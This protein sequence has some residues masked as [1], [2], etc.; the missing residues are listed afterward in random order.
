M[1]GF[2]EMKSHWVTSSLKQ[3]NRRVFIRDAAFFLFLYQSEASAHLTDIDSSGVMKRLTEPPA[4]GAKNHP[5]FPRIKPFIYRCSFHRPHLLSLLERWTKATRFILLWQE[6][7]L[8][9]RFDIWIQA[10]E[11]TSKGMQQSLGGF[12]WAPFGDAIHNSF[13]KV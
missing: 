6:R 11:N 5:V 4:I 13:Q 3:F 9:Q 10:K 7:F 8:D 2:I 1:F 12:T